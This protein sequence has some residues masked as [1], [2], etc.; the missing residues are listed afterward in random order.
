[1][2]ETSKT[3]YMN[4][5]LP[6][7]GE[8]LGPTWATDINTALTSIDGHDHD[9]VGRQL[10]S[11]A[12]GIDADLSFTVV[13]STSTTAFAA[14]NMKYLGLSLNT[15]PSTALPAASFPN[16]AFAGGTAGDL[17]F[18]DGSGN[19]I[20]LTSAGV[21]NASGVSAISFSASSTN[22]S[23]DTTIS[24]TDNLSYYPVD[25][26]GTGSITITLPSAPT[27]GRFFI[28]KDISGNAAT[29]NIIIR[30]TGTSQMVDGQKSTDTPAGY[31]INSNFGS[32]TVISR[33]NSL[34]FDVI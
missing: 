10:G 5:T 29:K 11:A 6:T 18:N 33:G 15:S 27:G 34:D 12:I 32:A 8:R 7:P 22:I 3:T 21:L 31:V 9:S 25:A 1:M 19:Q 20:Q 28:F 24:A 14:T 13:T 30:A 17:F 2:A 26:S 4:L 16:V 23:T